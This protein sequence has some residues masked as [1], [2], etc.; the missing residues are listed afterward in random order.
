MAV[1]RGV[2]GVSAYTPILKNLCRALF[3]LG[4]CHE[5]RKKRGG[6]KEEKRGREN[7]KR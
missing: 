1:S 5:E 3:R 2:S 4:H 6:K 7:G